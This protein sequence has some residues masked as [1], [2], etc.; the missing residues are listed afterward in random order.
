MMA[1]TLR[2]TL[3]SMAL[4]AL[5]VFSGAAMAADHAGKV[6]INTDAKAQLT[7]LHGIGDALA[8]RIIEYRKNQAFAQPADI[9]NVR[10]IGPSTFEKNKDRIVVGTPEP[11]KET[12][13][14]VPE[15]ADTSQESKPKS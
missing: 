12:P 8:D 2:L 5:I 9:Q 10:G 15:E 7:T 3:V 6:N 1:K 4:A 13:P 14:A 11:V